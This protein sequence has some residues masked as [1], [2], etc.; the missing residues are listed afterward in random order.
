MKCRESP[1]SIL[2]F[3]KLYTNSTKCRVICR[4]FPVESS[5]IS[6]RY[7]NLGHIN[8]DVN[9]KTRWLF[10]SGSFWAPLPYPRTFAVLRAWRGSRCYT[11]RCTHLPHSTANV[12]VLRPLHQKFPH[13]AFSVPPPAQRFSP[14]CHPPTNICPFTGESRS[15]CPI[16]TCILPH[17]TW[18]N[19]RAPGS[20]GEN[21]SLISADNASLHK[22]PHCLSLEI[23]FF[24]RSIP[25]SHLLP[26]GVNLR[27][28][29]P[30][31]C[32]T[33]RRESTS[34]FSCY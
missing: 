1:R 5:A 30:Q 24:L 16:A 22:K 18:A 4:L 20:V 12:R 34:V 3:S 23:F 25:S 33:R 14:P 26:S 6:F 15:P 31:N 2:P 32:G 17:L 10:R 29:H 8:P 13:S 19:V 21:S 28:R 7:K 11:A 27:R 9:T